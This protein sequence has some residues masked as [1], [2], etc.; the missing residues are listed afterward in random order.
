MINMDKMNL[1]LIEKLAVALFSFMRQA[2]LKCTL[3][4]QDELTY[5]YRIADITE[6][7]DGLAIQFVLDLPF[8]SSHQ[9]EDTEESIEKICYAVTLDLGCQIFKAK[10][11]QLL[12]FDN[13]KK[14]IMPN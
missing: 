9:V 4:K 6:S 11:Q 10:C 14:I 5:V 13:Q 1:S 7:G 2:G 3:G 12:R 8:L